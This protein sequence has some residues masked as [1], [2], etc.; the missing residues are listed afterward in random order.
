MAG[1]RSLGPPHSASV[2]L[3]RGLSKQVR[4]KH[5]PASEEHR[6]NMAALLPER[7]RDRDVL[8][9]APQHEKTS[10]RARSHPNQGFVKDVGAEQGPAGPGASA[11]RGQAQALRPRLNSAGGDGT[12]PR[13]MVLPESWGSGRLPSAS[14]RGR[15][16][17]RT[18]RQSPTARG[19]LGAPGQPRA[20]PQ[21]LR[22][23]R[24][25]WRCCQQPTQPTQ[26]CQTG[27]PSPS[28]VG[29]KPTRTTDFG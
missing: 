12:P 9:R 20:A 16:G 24:G 17:G 4:P 13:S 5:V 2:S 14:L 23:K 21:L 28:A 6:H 7:T 19:V 29:C 26:A 10:V 18:C 25:R 22:L 3:P 8:S 15:R 27:R 1:M 11:R